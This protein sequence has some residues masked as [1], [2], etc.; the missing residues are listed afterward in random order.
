MAF[1]NFKG[2]HKEDAMFSP[3]D[4]LAYL[5]EVGRYPRFKI[6]EGVVFCY[7]T[8]PPEEFLAEYKAK[9]VGEM[10]AE[11]MYLLGKTGGRIALVHRPSIGA[12]HVVALM[13]ELIALGVKRF[14][15]VGKAGTLQ[16][17]LGIG[18]LVVCERAIRDEG[19]SHHYIRPSKYASASKEMTARI[20]KA[21]DR[22]SL[23]Y[24]A[25][26][27]WTVD[28][29][30]RETVEEARQYQTEGVL[31]VE[32]EASALFAVAQLR[33]VEIGALFTVSDSLAE[34][35]WRPA[36]HSP[37]L[38]KVFEQMCEVAVEVLL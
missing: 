3:E 32:M 29:P 9:K 17:H 13:D 14:I 12:P 22:R 38:E 5:K 4:W 7:S 19:T 10:L 1:P 21:L 36:L 34:L 31:T 18:D 11:R 30:Y 35:E 26:T 27:S 6:P 37:K 15:I 16:K 20:K 24:A 23:A 33:R 2:K 25:G 28:A 8:S